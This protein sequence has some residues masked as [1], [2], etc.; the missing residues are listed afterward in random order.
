MHVLTQLAMP[1]PAPAGALGVT[2]GGGLSGAAGT[3]VDNKELLL[4]VSFTYLLVLLLI[5]C[6]AA[7]TVEHSWKMDYIKTRRLRL[8]HRPSLLAPPVSSTREARALAAFQ[9]F[10]LLCC[11]WLACVA[12]VSA[13]PPITCA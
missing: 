1:T 5:P 6:V 4:L 8:A 12:A 11:A 2:G 13:L 9:V 10:A 7:Y 3:A